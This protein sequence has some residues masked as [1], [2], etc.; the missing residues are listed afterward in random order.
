MLTLT[1]YEA[2]FEA[3]KPSMV[4][5]VYN[6]DIHSINITQEIKSELQKGKLLVLFKPEIKA[7]GASVDAA[8]ERWECLFFIIEN[9][10]LK[11][12]S[13]ETERKRI[14]NDTL[15]TSRLIK[16]L[17]FSTA[18]DNSQCHFFKT[19]NHSS[20]NHQFIGPVFNS[21]YGWLTEFS[22]LVPVF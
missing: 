7:D 19:I 13:N 18:A 12:N 4:S 2:W 6:I 9:L 11:G 15:E 21:M 8:Y 5:N 1:T 10:S 17:I 14:R 16:K 3:L 22:F 20:V